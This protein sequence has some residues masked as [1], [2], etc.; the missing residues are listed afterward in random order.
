MHLCDMLAKN[1]VAFCPSPE[2]LSDTEGKTGELS[3]LSEEI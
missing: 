2:N 3:S 1:L